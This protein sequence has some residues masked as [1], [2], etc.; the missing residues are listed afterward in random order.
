MRTAFRKRECAGVAFG[1]RHFFLTG[2]FIAFFN[3][4][5]TG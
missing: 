5:S 2:R 4:Y 1:R 3:S